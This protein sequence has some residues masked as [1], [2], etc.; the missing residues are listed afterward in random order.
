VPRTTHSRSAPQDPWQERLAQEAKGFCALFQDP[1]PRARIVDEALPR[2]VATLALLP[3]A[4]A[5]SHLLEL[6]SSPFISSVCYEMAWPGRITHANYFGSTE[7]RGSQALYEVGGTRTRTYDF[8]LFNIE[9]DEFPYPDATFDAILFCELIEHLAINPVWALAEMHRVL[10]PGGHLVVTTPNALSIDRVASALTGRRPFVDQYSPAFGYGARHNREFGM[11]E[12]DVLLGE[13]G[14][15][16]E[17]LVAR[18]LD[19][20]N[21]PTRMGRSLA[22]FVLR[23]FSDQ[24]RRQHL[25]LRARRRDVFRWRFPE[26]LFAASEYFRCVRHSWM[27]VGVNDTIQCEGGWEAP[28]QLPTG[29]WVRRLRGLEMLLPGGS[30][31]LRADDGASRLHVRL[32]GEIGDEAGETGIRIAVAPRN[33]ADSLLAQVHRT[34]PGGVWTD[35]E[36]ALSR[37]LAA[38]EVLIANIAVTIGQAVLVQ[39]MALG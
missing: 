32:R 31:H 4:T 15:D 26:M 9:T 14:F 18:D 22:R 3:P 11:R 12:L 19:T 20:P 6:G 35:V 1:E 29:E 33:A 38:G 36:V 10:R 16:I 24:P 23:R 28:E 2:I 25:L 39:R 30:T 27:K 17:T 21:L 7:R 13:T 34:V 8:D 5:S 37:P